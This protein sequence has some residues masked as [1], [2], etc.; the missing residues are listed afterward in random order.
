MGKDGERNTFLQCYVWVISRFGCCIFEVCRAISRAAIQHFYSI[1]RSL[2][3]ACGELYR[4]SVVGSLSECWSDPSLFCI[5]NSPTA[6]LQRTSDCGHAWLPGV[7]KP[8]LFF[9]PYFNPNVNSSWQP[10][11]LR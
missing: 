6:I 8:L 9:A 5:P 4:A 7:L 1:Y 11:G 3:A 10:V 2:S